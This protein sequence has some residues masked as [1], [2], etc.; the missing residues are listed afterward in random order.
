MIHNRDNDDGYYRFTN[1]EVCKECL[2]P[3]SVGLFLCTS[4]EHCCQLNM[5]SSLQ[6]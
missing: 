5:L 4:V 6:L 2:N 1:H 3:A